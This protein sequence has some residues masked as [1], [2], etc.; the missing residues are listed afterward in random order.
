MEHIGLFKDFVKST[1]SCCL[2]YS[3]TSLAIGQILCDTVFYLQH[4]KSISKFLAL[5]YQPQYYYRN[6]WICDLY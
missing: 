2:S 1:L 3:I 6:N 4:E 5:W